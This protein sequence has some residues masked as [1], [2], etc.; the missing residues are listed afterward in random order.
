MW[1]GREWGDVAGRGVICRLAAG[2]HPP[3]CTSWWSP[4]WLAM[5]QMTLGTTLNLTS[6]PLTNSSNTF[7]CSLL[8]LTQAQCFDLAVEWEPE[9]HRWH[10]DHQEWI[11]ASFPT[12]DSPGMSSYFIMWVNQYKLTVWLF[13]T[14]KQCGCLVGGEQVLQATC[15]CVFYGTMKLLLPYNGH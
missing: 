11:P 15:L 10:S 6:T 7:H 12:Q 8:A 2:V 14:H 4:L 9:Q 13:D 1:G 3:H 5:M